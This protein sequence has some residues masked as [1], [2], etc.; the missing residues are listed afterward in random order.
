MC[1]AEALFELLNPRPS[2]SSPERA[3]LPS[4]PDQ[5]SLMLRGI[6]VHSFCCQRCS[7]S[8]TIRQDLLSFTDLDSNYRP[9]SRHLVGSVQTIV[10]KPAGGS[11]FVC[12]CW[13]AFCRPLVPWSGM[14]QSAEGLLPKAKP[15]AT[16]PCC[17]LNTMVAIETGTATSLVKGCW[18]F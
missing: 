13:Q 4:S 14:L 6:F 2:S 11:A 18:K 15:V 8:H 12:N 5:R 9:K 1:L 3:G 17:H 10:W 16:W 7:G